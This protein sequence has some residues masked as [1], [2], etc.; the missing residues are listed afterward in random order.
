MR[1]TVYDAGIRSHRR[2]GTQSSRVSTE[3]TE[4]QLVGMILRITI[5]ATFFQ[6]LLFV[7]LCFFS[8]SEAAQSGARR[9]SRKGTDETKGFDYAHLY[10]H[11]S[12]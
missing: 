4:R 9:P 8:R 2:S 5:A 10:A 3:S 7:G 11:D 12:H 1:S 6:H